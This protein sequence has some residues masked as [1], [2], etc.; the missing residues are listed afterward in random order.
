MRFRIK[1]VLCV[2]VVIAITFSVTAALLISRSFQTSLNQALEMHQELCRMLCQTLYDTNPNDQASFLMQQEQGYAS[3]C[4]VCLSEK[5]DIIYETSKIFPVPDEFAAKSQMIWNSSGAYYHLITCPVKNAQMVLAWDISAIYQSRDVQLL[6]YYSVYILA[7]L[8]SGLLVWL[9]CTVV[10]KPLEKLTNATQ[11][12]GAGNLL[13]E[14]PVSTDDEIGYLASEFN[15]MIEKLKSKQD[16]MEN[17]LYRQQR[18]IGALTHE[19]KTPLTAIMGYTEMLKVGLLDQ[20][21]RDHAIEYIST[22]SKRLDVMSHQLIELILMEN[23]SIELVPASPDRIVLQSVNTLEPL[24]HQNNIAVQCEC[25]PGQCLMNP[26]LV[27]ILLTNLLDNARKASSPGGQIRVASHMTED[28][29]SIQIKDNGYGIP[30]ED[31]PYILE[32]FYRVDKSRSHA[33]GGVG[34]GLAL[35]QKIAD[36]HDGTIAFSS[37]VNQGTCVTVALKGGRL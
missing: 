13:T 11:L 5:D 15:S 37:E 14:V 23:D 21:E 3:W 31:L 26:T 28:G 33:Q 32:P 12:V 7:M 4:Y 25:E 27:H 19:L 1:I 24:L 20:E 18:F 16:E 22:E 36:V 9:T 6:N 17:T 30:E 29:C 8:L 10:V 2:L 34:I 35:C